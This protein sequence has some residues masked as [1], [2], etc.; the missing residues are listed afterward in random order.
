ME[1]AMLAVC[2]LGSIPRRG[3]PEGAVGGTGE[4]A[5]Y[6]VDVEVCD[7]EAFGVEE[8]SGGGVGGVKVPGAE[9]G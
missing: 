8:G 6:G 7:G 1:Q 9:Q 5:V 4:G 3:A 2:F